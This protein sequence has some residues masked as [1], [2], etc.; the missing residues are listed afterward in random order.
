MFWRW[1]L[2]LGLV[3][4]MQV[5]EVPA[6]GAVLLL[7]VARPLSYTCRSCTRVYDRAT[8]LSRHYQWSGHGPVEPEIVKELHGVDGNRAG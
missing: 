8:D 5:D 1:F 2:F 6:A 7:A 3:V 4:A